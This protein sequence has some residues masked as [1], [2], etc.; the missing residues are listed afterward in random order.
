MTDRE[1]LAIRPLRNA[2][3]DPISSLLQITSFAAHA[4][5]GRPPM[6]TTTFS[7]ARARLDANARNL[8]LW[9]LQGWLAMFFI[10]AGWAKVSEP[11]TNLV[12]LMGWPAFA[13]ENLVRGLGVAEMVLA[14]GVL[15]PL[16]SWRLFRP[17]LLTSAFG[18]M[19]LE[20]AMLGVHVLNRDVG[21][22]V[23]N[24]LLLAIT[25]PVLLGRRR[26]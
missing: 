4:V 20:A 19:V 6:T 25:I 2:D 7:P 23:V 8:A 15:T 11:M 5:A 24:L 10:A 3:V 22:S 13:P 12:A 21:L 18:L 17:A 9:T 16:L 26:G 14:V 1:T